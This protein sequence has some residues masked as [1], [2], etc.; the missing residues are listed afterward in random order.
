M[1]YLLYIRAEI[2]LSGFPLKKLHYTVDR[3]GASI[4]SAGNMSTIEKSP[5]QTVNIKKNSVPGKGLYKNY[6]RAL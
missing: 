2:E 1:F 5:Y 3:D 6:L 4:L